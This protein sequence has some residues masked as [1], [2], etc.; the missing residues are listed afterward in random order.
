MPQHQPKKFDLKPEGL[1]EAQISNHRDI[2][3]A[4]YI[5]KLN[6]IDERQRKTDLSTAN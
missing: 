3:Y 4:G 6:E 5:N 2:L 1:S